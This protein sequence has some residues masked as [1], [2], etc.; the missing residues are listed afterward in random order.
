MFF[1]DLCTIARNHVEGENPL[2]STEDP[3]NR[4]S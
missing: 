2:H 4:N 1:N 3:T